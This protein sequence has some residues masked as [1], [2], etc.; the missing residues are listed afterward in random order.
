M[1]ALY[2][3]NFNL[4]ITCSVLVSMV[5]ICGATE[6]KL[7]NSFD[8]EFSYISPKT[9]KFRVKLQDS[10]FPKHLNLHFEYSIS[11]NV[12]ADVY[13]TLQ[14]KGDDI[15]AVLI[16]TVCRFLSEYNHDKYR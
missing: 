9:M 13:K 4:S 7:N 12:P 2:S 6:C 14:V 5:T 3:S 8:L 16:K 11:W 1:F 10:S 15:C